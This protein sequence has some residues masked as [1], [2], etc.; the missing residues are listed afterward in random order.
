MVKKQRTVVLECALWGG[1]GGQTLF[2]K[3][4]SHKGWG[5]FGVLYSSVISYIIKSLRLKN[6]HFKIQARK[7]KIWAE[8]TFCK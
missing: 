2:V 6:P 8:A 7:V 5:P 4:P 3:K 1:P